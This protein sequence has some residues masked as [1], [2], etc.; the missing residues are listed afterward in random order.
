MTKWTTYGD[1]TVLRRC[2]ALINVPTGGHNYAATAHAVLVE[3]VTRLLRPFMHSEVQGLVVTGGVAQNMHLNTAL[4]EAFGLPVHVPPDPT[5][6]GLSIGHLYLLL[7]PQQRQEVT[8][9]G[10]HARDLKV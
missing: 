8:F 2:K 1:A 5:D 10:L 4:E 7:K 6:A 9:L 3:L